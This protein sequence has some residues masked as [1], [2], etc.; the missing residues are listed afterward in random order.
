MKS[1]QI[2]EKKW[3]EK[4]RQLTML[5]EYD[6]TFRSVSVVFLEPKKYNNTDTPLPL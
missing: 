6:G 3:V 5:L 2:L 1:P 4:D